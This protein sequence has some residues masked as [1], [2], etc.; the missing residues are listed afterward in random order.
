MLRKILQ[1]EYQTSIA[2]ELTPKDG[3]GNVILQQ[4]GSSKPNNPNPNELEQG[5][6][7]TNEV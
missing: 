1:S 5:K 2:I 7:E 4:K 3:T 6:A